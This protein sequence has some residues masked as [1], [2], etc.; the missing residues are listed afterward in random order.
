MTTTASVNTRIQLSVK[1]ESADTTCSTS[2][3]KGPWEFDTKVPAYGPGASSEDHIPAASP[4]QGQIPA[5][6]RLATDEELHDRIRAAKETLGDRVVVL[7]HFYQR[8]E[9]VQH[10]D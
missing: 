1:G 9:I 7:G 3:A 5:E 6:Y 10:A 8:D 2:L 4:V